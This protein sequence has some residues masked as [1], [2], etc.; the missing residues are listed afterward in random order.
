MLQRT[1]RVEYRRIQMDLPICRYSELGAKLN[2]TLVHLWTSEHL[3]FTLV[4]VGFL[5]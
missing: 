3:R 1:R 5:E 4:G 2:S